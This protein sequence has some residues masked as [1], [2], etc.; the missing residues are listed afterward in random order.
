M[1]CASLD[2]ILLLFQGFALVTLFVYMQMCC[3]LI[4]LYVPEIMAESV[5]Q[6]IE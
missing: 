3:M 5:F 4:G 2:I 6:H 1:A